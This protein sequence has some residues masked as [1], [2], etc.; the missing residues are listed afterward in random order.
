MSI[1]E[2]A[3]A[4]LRYTVRR[5]SGAA[6]GLR[7]P[8][9][10]SISHRAVILGAL[11]DGETRIEGFL[12]ARDTLA[13]VAALRALGVAIKGPEAG[14]VAVRGR[15]LH[16]LRA[17]GAA[18]DLGNSG[19]GMRLL[20]GVLAGQRFGCE[21]VGDSSLSRR[22]MGRVVEPLR[23]MGADIEASAAG[24]PPL[25]MAPG[26]AG[27]R[28]ICYRMPVASA[29]VKSCLL[30]AGLYAMGETRVI[31]AA[32]SRDHTER[33]LRGFGYRVDSGDGAVALTGGGRLRT[34]RIEVPGDISSAA[35]FLAGVA[36]TPGAELTV[37]GLGVNPTRTGLL[38]ALRR[39]GASI[40]LLGE[41]DSGG[42]PVA[43]VRV[44]GAR[45]HGIDIEPAL[46]PAMIDEL[47]VFFVAAACAEG[48]SRVRGAAELRVKESDRIAVMAEVLETFGI[49]VRPTADGIDITGAESLR[50]GRVD[51]GGD[52]RVAMAA[53]V[54]ALRSDAPVVIEDCA[55]VATS[56]PE[57]P[58]IAGDFGLAVE[59]E[60]A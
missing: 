3:A 8:G 36:M 20:A 32:P 10:K 59:V 39:M 31:E 46:V 7:V 40:D 51:S 41:H 50:G 13:T 12:E 58:R 22:P 47:P 4:G 9:D 57:F 38:T 5:G 54:A 23:A 16:G 48:R 14:R 26:G 21:M 56:F 1:P 27:L 25:R 28:G 30:L 33:M 42:E 44:R 34:T 35:F 6:S 15:G 53:A 37:Q 18:L 17:P 60:S 55:N 29:Q 11:A 45:L 2:H 49:A 24:T 52:H 19:T 43:D